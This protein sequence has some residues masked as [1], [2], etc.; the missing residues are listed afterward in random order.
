VWEEREDWQPLTN[1]RMATAKMSF[2][3]AFSIGTKTKKGILPLSL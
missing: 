1:S 3:M 2:F